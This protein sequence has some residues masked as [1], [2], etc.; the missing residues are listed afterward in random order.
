MRVYTLETDK[1]VPY[2]DRHVRFY[3]TS[4]ENADK[5]LYV[6]KDHFCNVDFHGFYEDTEL[7]GYW[8]EHINDDPKEIAERNLN[9]GFAFARDYG[10][11][12]L[13]DTQSEMLEEI[14]KKIPRR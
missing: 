10:D 4:K 2:G 8:K 5:F 14:M 7:C 9:W 13:T 12:K 6:F 1:V 11:D 3:F